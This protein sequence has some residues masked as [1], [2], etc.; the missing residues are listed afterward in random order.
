MATAT[1]TVRFGRRST[2][3]LILGFS[4]PR[5]IALAAAGSI[6]IIGLVSAGGYGFIV[7][8]IVWAPLAA[9]ALGGWCL[10]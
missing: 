4:T 5:V 10:S 8:G 6:A 2:R 9:S 7:A 1:P 3:G